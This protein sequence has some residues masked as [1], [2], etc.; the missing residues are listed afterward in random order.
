MK[1]PEKNI[2]HQ[3]DKNLEIETGLETIIEIVLEIHK[4]EI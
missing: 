4:T 2:N 1:D 3:E